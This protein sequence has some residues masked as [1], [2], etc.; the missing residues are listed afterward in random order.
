L[1]T[2][3]IHVLIPMSGQ[4]T[5][6]Q[7]AG[8]TDPKPLIP[9]NG[10]PMVQRLLERFPIEWSCTF[11][12][13][14]NHKE[15][16][17]PVLLKKLRP[18]SQILYVPVHAVGPS[19]PL[20]Y[21]IPFLPVDETILV[22][23]CDY[24]LIWDPIQFQQFISYTDCD[25]CLVSYKGFHA[26]YLSDVPYA[27]SR[28]EGELVKQV[29]EKG[30]FTSQ[31]ENEYASCGA[32]FFKNKQTLSEALDYQVK[33]DL[34]VNGEF[35]TSLTVEA[36]LQK[37]PNAHVRVFEIPYFFQW[38]TPDDLKD[39][40]YWEKSYV[41]KNKFEHAVKTTEQVYIPMAGLG[42]RFK[43]LT[44]KKKPFIELNGTKMYEKAIQSLPKAINTA[45]VSLNEVAN[46]I[47]KNYKFKSLAETPAGQALTVEAG[48]DL[49][50][51]TQ[52]VLVSA[53]DHGVV[54]DPVKW[55]QFQESDCDAAVF[56]IRGFPGT[57][58]SPKSYSYVASKDI[59]GQFP[60]VVRIGTKEMLSPTPQ[61]DYLL[62]GTFWFKNSVILK[63]GIDELKASAQRVNNE[64]YLDGI[65]D[66]LLKKNYKCVVF[67]LDG[68]FNWGDP[69]S[70]KESLYWEEVFS[71][72]TLDQRSPFPNVKF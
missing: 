68:Y 33:N 57:R 14:E 71:G 18:H 24:G 3:P 55:K 44:S 70:L 22:S 72:H 8:Y 15:S 42:S 69:E 46:E 36:L 40:E 56:C 61:N 26:H 23:Y 25:A 62:V 12:L 63:Q 47:P 9:V 27:Y 49:L 32:Y 5:R 4:G 34:K 35:Y 65:F 7:K 16:Q 51:P 53:C 21:S 13:A 11:V 41:Q 10:T 19:Y 31:R 59:G 54:I 17:L 43:P 48:L 39:F 60:A 38:G 64:L 1:K 52:S 30:S 29:K 45:L 67:P 58:R 66:V 20:Q 50:N 6:Y 2:K 37:N 28:M